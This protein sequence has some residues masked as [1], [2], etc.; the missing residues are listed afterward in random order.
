MVICLHVG[1][2]AGGYIGVDIFFALSGF[3]ITT[4]LYEEWERSGAIS[5][6]R[7]YECRG[8][9]LL[10][11]LWLLVAGFIVLVLAVNPFAGLWPLGSLVT[12][13]LLFANN[14]VTA[15]AP[16]HGRVL[17]ALVPTWTLAQ[18]VQFYLL[19]PVALSILL[20]FGAR[21]P[22]VLCLLALAVGTLFATAPLVRDAYPDY[23][24][25]TDPLARGA[26]LLLG[27][28][29]AVAWRAR[30]MPKV[31]RSTAA[32]WA[33][34]G[35]LIAVL[36]AATPIPEQSTYLSAAALA[37]L[38]ISNLLSGSRRP[39]RL[40]VL[41]PGQ[42]SDR[43]VLSGFLSSRPLLAT[44]RISYGLY[45]YHLPIYCLL[46]HYVPGRS[47]YI[48][49]PTVLAASYAAAA[50]SWWAIERPAIH[51]R[52]AAGT[53]ARWFGAWGTTARSKNRPSLSA[54]G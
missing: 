26:E 51:G 41:R 36:V 54:P 49:A 16:T 21:P 28:G 38:L 32:G 10:P 37:A 12:T 6:R 3:L 27:A 11:A 17:G 9:R 7:F 4:L 53:R 19:W 47:P 22:A 46:W 39:G 43:C 20:R 1:L 8:R 30:L 29:A 5:L 33:L 14:W 34:A 35:G 52:G 24:P 2:L 44:G 45:L 15:L 25:Y 13:T 48:Y 42:L 40:S 18:E 23:N 31:L 50:L